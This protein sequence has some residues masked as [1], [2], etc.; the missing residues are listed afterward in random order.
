MFQLVWKSFLIIQQFYIVIPTSTNLQ[1]EFNA[2]LFLPIW[3]SESLGNIRP[4]TRSSHVETNDSEEELNA[5]NPHEEKKILDPKEQQ[6][7]MISFDKIF[8]AFWK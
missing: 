6:T 2:K 4:N 3:T 8:G 1:K 5:E 7:V